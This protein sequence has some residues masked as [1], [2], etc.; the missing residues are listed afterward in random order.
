MPGS[1]W[2]NIVSTLFWM[3]ASFALAGVGVALLMKKP[4]RPRRWAVLLWL[5]IP[6]LIAFIL[7]SLALDFYY[8]SSSFY[9]FSAPVTMIG[10]LLFVV[11]PSSQRSMLPAIL[12]GHL[13]G[14]VMFIGLSAHVEP[15]LFR[16]L[17]AGWAT[18]QMRDISDANPLFLWRLENAEYRQR[19]LKYAVDGYMVPEATLKML[20]EKGVRPF[21]AQQD[22][23]DNLSAFQVAI[24]YRNLPAVRMFSAQLVGDSPQAAR[25]RHA[26]L[27]DNPLS[28]GMRFGSGLG[29]GL[30][31]MTVE[32]ETDI[33]RILLAKMPELASDKLYASF[34]QDDDKASV[35]FLWQYRQPENRDYRC[36]A[37]ALMGKTS[38]CE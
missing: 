14:L 38:G 25:N 26:V 2:L 12:C 35:A 15:S 4:R 36:Q 19:M 27:A 13:T 22:G 28:K 1:L 10:M 29:L 32:K 33:A 16:N 30:G 9:L 23:T 37:L 7:F 5:L 18:H 3:V 6:Q 11:F 34:L 17:Q 31:A 8:V 24:E 20:V 21:E